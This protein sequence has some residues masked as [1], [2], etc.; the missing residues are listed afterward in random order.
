M[1]ETSKV[2]DWSADDRAELFEETAAK[3]GVA[4]P[5][6]VE[7]D[8]WICWTLD[9]V[10]ATAFREA[11]VFKGGTTLS[12]VFRVIERFSEDIDLS[13]DRVLLGFEDA[14]DPAKAASKS[15][16]KNLITALR[17]ACD[18]WVQGPFREALVE[19][20]SSRLTGTRVEIAVDGTDPSTLYFKYPPALREEFYG[21]ATYIQP[22]IRLELGG[23]AE[24][25]PVIDSTIKSF[26]AEAFP[27]V[28]VDPDV[29]V[30]VLDPERTFW[31]KAT[32]AHA[33]FHLPEQKGVGDRRSRHYYDLVMLARSDIGAR[34]LM[35]DALRAAVVE[36]KRLF[37]S[38]PA[39]QY[40]TAVRGTF[41]IV[42]PADRLPALRT[43]YLKMREMLFTV[44]PDF[45][46]LIEELAQLEGKINQ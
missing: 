30:R 1:T 14:K 34:A 33:D 41:R 37:F 26:C 4:S 24:L 17:S 19:K 8:Y 22:S 23:R 10:F 25:W 2:A 12:K 28:V 16:A 11:L 29:P 42:P 18:A 35:N 7:K 31:E 27:G 9:A 20:M 45:D 36:H 39:A 44:P 32:I 15:K 38:S 46:R 43:D 40:E 21:T 5:V 13:V 6:A 3:I